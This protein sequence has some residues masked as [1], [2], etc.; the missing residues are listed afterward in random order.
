MAASSCNSRSFFETIPFANEGGCELMLLEVVK[1]VAELANDSWLGVRTLPFWS[2]NERKQ[3]L[4]VFDLNSNFS[5]CWNL[6]IIS[7]TGPFRS[8][9]SFAKD[10]SDL[11]IVSF[12]STYIDKAR[13]RKRKFFDDD[14]FAVSFGDAL[15]SAIFLLGEGD[16]DKIKERL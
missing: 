12:R 16:W 5:K 13:L 7:L 11:S 10:S 3:T 6:L 9:G 2:G 1:R 15:G 4:G 14:G 8:F